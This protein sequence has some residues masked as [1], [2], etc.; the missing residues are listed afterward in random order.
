[1]NSLSVKLLEAPKAA[2]CFWVPHPFNDF[3]K[4][5]SSAEFSA[6]HSNVQTGNLSPLVPPSLFNS[7]K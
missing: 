7:Y 2:V 5:Q 6:D 3:P 1:M 4:C